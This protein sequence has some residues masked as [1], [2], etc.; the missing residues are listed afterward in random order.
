MP[1]FPAGVQSSMVALVA[2][3]ALWWL[4][5]RWPQDGWCALLLPLQPLSAL[6]ALVTVSTCS[7]HLHLGR[8]ADRFFPLSQLCSSSQTAPFPRLPAEVMLEEEVREA[9]LS[10]AGT[11]AGVQGGHV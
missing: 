11:A 7:P 6:A 9:V 2:V 3:S 8:A 1:L 5:L 10:T 4:C